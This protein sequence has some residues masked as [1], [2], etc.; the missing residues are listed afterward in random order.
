MLIALLLTLYAGLSAIEAAAAFCLDGAMITDEHL[1]RLKCKQLI[2][3]QR[4][5]ISSKL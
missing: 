4:H 2:V 1:T 5:T 3:D